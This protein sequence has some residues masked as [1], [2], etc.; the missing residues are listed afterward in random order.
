MLID[1]ADLQGVKTLSMDNMAVCDQLT[2]GIMMMWYGKLM[3]W[4]YHSFLFV[5]N[6]ASQAQALCAFS[7][8]WHK[9]QQS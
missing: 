1:N 8:E 9:Q 4:I 7:P 2:Q 5:A 3:F 6:I